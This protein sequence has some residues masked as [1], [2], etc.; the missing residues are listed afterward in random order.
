M[1]NSRG[2]LSV[3]RPLLSS[4]TKGG[5]TV[6]CEGAFR[7]LEGFYRMRFALDF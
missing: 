4:E 7:F 6:G 2:S 3:P 1:R 5:A